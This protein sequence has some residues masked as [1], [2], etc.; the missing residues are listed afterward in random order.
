MLGKAL[1]TLL[2]SA[3]YLSSSDADLRN[4]NSTM[5]VFNKHNPQIVIHLAGRVGGIKANMENLGGFFYDNIKINTNVL[6]ASRIFNAEK[7]LSTLSTCVYPDNA[8][9]P[10]TENQIN[11]GEPHHSNYAYAYAKRMIDVQ[12]RAYR[13]QY[14]CNF[15]TVVPNNMFGPHDNFDLEDSHV[16]PALVR[17][18]YEAKSFGTPVKLWG[19]GSPL[20][21]FTYSYDMAKIIVF[22]LK[23]Y[24]ECEPI[25]IGNTN[26]YS[27]REIA[28][29]ISYFFDYKGEVF[30]DT[31]GPPGQFRKPS[32][33]K[34][35]INL[36]WQ[37]NNFIDIDTSLEEVCLWFEKNYQKARGVKK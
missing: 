18:I 35:L 13:Q 12:S 9:Y 33:N 17:K 27:I 22:V 25:N 32:C 29:K 24:N 26:E 31:S 30:W 8:K 7:V 10:L 36:G 3:I 5:D 15:I 34:K 37:E 16:I 28:N 20:R 11:N 23:N 21:E 19:D 2:P 14:G 1:K 4:F 6:E